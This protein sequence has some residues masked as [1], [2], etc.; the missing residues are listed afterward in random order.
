MVGFA[1][2]RLGVESLPRGAYPMQQVRAYWSRRGE[3]LF[4]TVMAVLLMA[5]VIIRFWRAVGPAGSEHRFALGFTGFIIIAIWVLAL[6][7][8]RDLDKLAGQAEEEQ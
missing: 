2:W 6:R 3:F 5:N 4:L 1:A 7:H 8:T